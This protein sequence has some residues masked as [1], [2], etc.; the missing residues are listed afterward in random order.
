MLPVISSNFK[1]TIAEGEK[2]CGTEKD[3][4][5]KLRLGILWSEPRHRRHRQ[6]R[7]FHAVLKITKI[8]KLKYSGTFTRDKSMV[9]S[10][11][12]A[13]ACFQQAASCLRP[14]S[15][16]MTLGCVSSCLI[17]QLWLFRFVLAARKQPYLGQKAAPKAIITREP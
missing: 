4:E 5:P 13:L 17:S 16:P 12:V 10:S 15:R 9:R 2:N 1:R 7:Y 3:F 8:Y 11:S 14:L 6:E